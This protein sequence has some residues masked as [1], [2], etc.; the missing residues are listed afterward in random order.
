VVAP[1]GIP[2]LE[3]LEAGESL[4]HSWGFSVLRAPHLTDRHRFNAGTPEA[5]IEDLTWALTAPDIDA[6]WLARGGYGCMHCLPSLPKKI[7]SRPIIG[8]SDA[9]ALFSAL[10]KQAPHKNLIHGP[11]LETIATR[12]DDLTRAR[13]QSILAGHPVKPIPATHFAGPKHEVQGKVL[14]GNLCVLASL[15]GTPWALKA[16]DAIVVLEDVTEAP[17]R[18]D[19]LLTQLRLSSALDGARAIALGDFIKCN[20][21][22]NANY[23]LEDVLHDAL[24]PL[25]IP[26]WSNL[27]TGHATQNLAWRVATEGR[28]GPHGLSQ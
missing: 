22:P 8:C 26:I 13:I 5:R 24:A 16:K 10:E 2:H 23:T 14:G 17:Y 15:A 1:A 20:P 9:T 18:I 19:R 11:M 21:P 7:D 6:V 27:P 12:V 28:L 25:N 4:L 3:G